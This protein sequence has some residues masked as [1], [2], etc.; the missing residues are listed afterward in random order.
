MESDA[1][2]DIHGGLTSSLHFFGGRK[3][4]S[5]SDCTPIVSAQQFDK[6][7]LTMGFYLDIPVTIPGKKV[8]VFSNGKGFEV[9]F[10]GTT[11]GRIR[12]GVLSAEEGRGLAETCAGHPALFILALREDGMSFDLFRQGVRL[13]SA[14]D[15]GLMLGK[16]A[17]T[18]LSGLG[19]LTLGCD[20]GGKHCFQ[21]TL[22]AF[23]FERRRAEGD[24]AV[25]ALHEEIMTKELGLDDHCG[26]GVVQK[27]EG[28]ECDP[29][30]TEK[31]L[32]SCGC[33]CKAQCPSYSD[34]LG[35][36]DAA[37][38]EISGTGRL[39]GDR[40]DLSCAAGHSPSPPHVTQD[41]VFCGVDKAGKWSTRVMSCLRKCS[42]WKEPWV[43]SGRFEVDKRRY[44]TPEMP[45]LDG[46]WVNVKCLDPAQPSLGQPQPQRLFCV[47]GTVEPLTLECREACSIDGEGLALGLVLAASGANLNRGASTLKCADNFEPP[48]LLRRPPGSS[49][50]GSVSAEGHAGAFLDAGGSSDNFLRREGDGKMGS[51]ESAVERAGA[52]ETGR[53]ERGS[54]EE[55]EGMRAQVVSCDEGQLSGASL[56]CFEPCPG[57]S[58]NELSKRQVIASRQDAVDGFAGLPAGSEVA[59]SCKDGFSPAGLASGELMGTGA[60]ASIRCEGGAWAALPLECVAPCD[61]FPEKPAEFLVDISAG[62]RSLSKVPVGTL[63]RIRCAPGYAPAAGDLR[64]AETVYCVGGSTGYTQDTMHCLKLCASL[65]EVDSLLYKQ[66]SDSLP[67]PPFRQGQTVLFECAEGFSPSDPQV[68]T[69]ISVCQGGNWSPLSFE[70]SSSCPPFPVEEATEKEGLLLTGV[71]PSELQHDKQWRRHSVAVRLQCPPGTQGHLKESTQDVKCINGE[72]E[73]ITLQCAEVCTEYKKLPLE[74]YKIEGTGG[75]LEQ[76]ASRVLKCAEGFDAVEGE[77]GEEV[78]CIHGEWTISTLECG[79][80]CGPFVSKE[81]KA[82]YQILKVE[83]PSGA[84]IDIGNTVVPHGTVVEVACRD[85][86]ATADASGRMMT[87][88]VVCRSGA[89]SSQQ[90]T[91]FTRCGVP[92]FGN[93]GG[94]TSRLENPVLPMW[95]A[96]KLPE[97][98]TPE[99]DELVNG[100]GN[101]TDTAEEASESDNLD[102][103]SGEAQEEGEGEESLPDTTQWLDAKQT[104]LKL[105]PP[106]SLA[107]FVGCKP[108]MTPQPAAPEKQSIVCMNG[109]FTEP[110]IQC[111]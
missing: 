78:R 11:G 79:K 19:Q 75:G 106:H 70:C 52:G 101:A 58:A 41:S 105:G 107:L 110:T 87:E 108:G 65:P 111:F 99:R 38:F 3:L 14:E 76:G 21:G 6:G 17:R 62:S 84:L 49:S 51:E 85:V 18:Q 28:E 93:A 10:V 40:V 80:H 73:A 86:Y 88:E 25:K 26:D 53:E 9:G 2:A 43:E 56:K 90:L 15:K 45:M 57:L 64:D 36:V 23:F 29:L 5:S 104:F 83:H 7:Q 48:L 1:H 109:T 74:A 13:N 94:M 42:L 91:C 31:G 24:E 50:S 71:S 33:N 54:E 47:D 8:V 37:R 68:T 61:A 102:Q 81:P 60:S 12:F 103:S 72:W 98:E 77:E 20:G 89:W 59:F 82:Y 30:A 44:L 96:E 46:E 97:A 63:V 4:K 55:S 66:A 16:D 22:G 39:K 95:S 35:E 32:D 67:P 27:E 100:T 69:G 92:S 34:A